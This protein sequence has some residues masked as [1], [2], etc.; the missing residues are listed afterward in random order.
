MGVVAGTPRAEFGPD[1]TQRVGEKVKVGRKFAHGRR[2]PPFFR[3]RC[4]RVAP[5]TE[6]APET[7]LTRGAA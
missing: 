2:G 5:V 4:S 3:V 7:E 1:R 6:T